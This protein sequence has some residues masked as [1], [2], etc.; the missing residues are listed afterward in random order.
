[1]LSLSK[2][3]KSYNKDI[4]VLNNI[5]L[6]IKKGEL[7]F[8]VGMSGAGKTTLMK[9]ITREEKPTEGKITLYDSSK[10]DYIDIEKIKPHIYRRKLGIIFQDYKLIETKNVYENIA[11]PL[12]VFGEQRKIIKQEV[13]RIAQIVGI[14]YLLYKKT[15][16]LSGGERQRVGIARALVTKPE[17]L[18]ADEPTGNLDYKTSTDIMKLLSD[19]NKQG[20]TV[21]MIT[22]DTNVVKNQPGRIIQIHEGK[23][24]Q[25]LSK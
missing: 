2:I 7:V 25:D 17:I 8:I 19:I 4:L 13:E 11:Y 9:L 10:K 15:T 22:H 24:I 3:Y 12:H 6:F 5:N 14:D 21:I 20:T 16:E 23:V 1:M 18:L